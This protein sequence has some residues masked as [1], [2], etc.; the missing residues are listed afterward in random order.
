M[1]TLLQDAG[2]LC[3]A[4]LTWNIRK[5]RFRLGGARG[6][7]PCQSPGDSG[8]ALETRCDAATGWNE[9]ARF[10][11]VCPLLRQTADGSWRCGVDAADV[12]P[13]WGRV[14]ATSVVLGLCGLIALGGAVFVGLRA[15]GVGLTP[16]MVFWPPAWSEITPARAEAYHRRALLAQSRGDSREALL[17]LA[18][19]HDLDP[20][21]HDVARLLAKL[22]QTG[23]PHLS[24]RLYRHLL[25]HHPER[26][27][28]VAADWA[29]ALLA[30]RDYRALQGL[31]GAQ[32]LAAPRATAAWLEA[33]LFSAR[34]TR[35][36]E[37]LVEL[38]ANGE[39]DRSVAPWIELFLRVENGTNDEARNRLRAAAE[40]I[41]TPHHL[42]LTV[43]MMVRH[44]AARE[45][46]DL[47]ESPPVPLPTRERRLLRLDTLAALGWQS[48]RAA[49]F[50]LLLSAPAHAAQVELA[51][52]HL[53]RFP[54]EALRSRLL[55]KLSA[56]PPLLAP[57]DY[58][59]QL[60][61]L[62]LAARAGDEAE[63]AH[64]AAVVRRL[65][66]GVF[67]T[68]DAMVIELG[69]TGRADRLLNFLPILQP[70]PLEVLYALLD[71]TGPR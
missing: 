22:Y 3:G 35:D 33:L 41:R 58:P 37:A 23:Q 5:T 13:F 71:S 69:Q 2:R 53:I 42:L 16:R 51:V 57:G 70:L 38:L 46:L 17:A 14:L 15:Q 28:A 68:L 48:P 11:C 45:A 59:A 66:G 30:R 18:V 19:A 7:A 49:E 6:P 24:D 65:S 60:A 40:A 36:Y 4:A 63:L 43:R 29:R 9:P 10:R 26:R 61:L 62:C 12:R 55:A 27:D 25:I 50:D 21:N 8:R 32:L 39:L 34:Q 52:A 54:D 64:R 44:G 1:W 31:A 20:L 56:D 67:A 47:I